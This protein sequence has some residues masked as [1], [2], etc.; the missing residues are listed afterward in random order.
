MARLTG[1]QLLSLKRS[2]L[3]KIFPFLISFIFLTTIFLTKPLSVSAAH[4]DL[5]R[6][7]AWW[8]IKISNPCVPLGTPAMDVSPALFNV[9]CSNG[10]IYKFDP[11]VSVLG[12]APLASGEIAIAYHSS[13]TEGYV[14]SSV[15]NVYRHDSNFIFSSTQPINTAV[16]PGNAPVDLYSTK[17][18]NS[19][20]DVWQFL[21]GNWNKVGS[22]AMGLSEKMVSIDTYIISD[23]GDVYNLP[24]GGNLSSKLNINNF[25]PYAN[26]SSPAVKTVGDYVLAKNGKYYIFNASFGIW[27]DGNVT[28][29]VSFNARSLTLV[30]SDWVLEGGGP[31]S[32]LN[33]KVFNDINGNGIKNAGEDFIQFDTSIV[34]SVTLDGNQIIPNATG[35]YST[36]ITSTPNT[37]SLGINP[38]GSIGSGWGARGCSFSDVAS[39]TYNPPSDPNC[40]GGYCTTSTFSVASGGTITVYLGVSR[41]DLTISAGPSLNSGLLTTGSTVNFK[42]TVKNTGGVTAGGTSNLF[43]I[44]TA[45]GDVTPLQPYP[46]ITALNPGLSQQ[47][48]SG[49]WPFIPSG[50]HTVKLCADQPTSNVIEANESN[51][52]SSWTFTVTTP[53]PT[54]TRTPTPTPTRTPTP[55]PTP[56][57]TYTI[58]GNVYIDDGAGTQC[59]GA[60]CGAGNGLKDGAE[61]NYTATIPTIKIGAM[62][63]TS[64]SGGAYEF[65]G[66]T[67]GGTNYDV[68][69]TAPPRYMISHGGISP[70]TNPRTVIV[71][72]ANEVA[73]FGIVVAP[74][75]YFYM[76]DSSVPHGYGDI[77]EDGQITNL[78]AGLTVIAG[79]LSEIQKK[80]GDVDNN[81]AVDFVGDGITISKFSAGISST[82]WVCASLNYTISGIVYLDENRNGTKDGTEPYYASA[83][84]TRSPGGGVSSPVNN[85]CTADAS[86]A[87][88]TS[89]DANP[90]YSFTELGAGAGGTR[91]YVTI[92]D[93]PAGYV[94]DSA[95]QSLLLGNPGNPERNGTINFALEP[96]PTYTI[97]GSVFVDTNKDGVK[98][99]A[100]VNYTAGSIT[101]T[102]TG[103]TVSYPASGQFTVSNLPAGTYIISYTSLPSEYS[104]IYP[105]T[106]PPSQFEVIVGPPSCS[107]DIAHGSSCLIDDSIINLNFAIAPAD[108]WIQSTCTD[109]RFDNGFNYYI[110]STGTCGGAGGAYASVTAATCTT[111]GIIFSGENNAVF[112]QGNA[113]QTPYGWVVGGSSYPELFTPSR[114]NVIRTSYKYMSGKIKQAGLPPT[115]I[116]GSCGT[117]GKNPCVLGAGFNN[118]LYIADGDLIFSGQGTPKSYTFPE[119]NYVIL[120]DGKLTIK[121]R[122]IVQKGS[123]VT[124]IV[125]GDIIIDPSVGNTNIEGFTSTTP[126]IEGFYSAD[127]SFII[128]GTNNCSV[129]A[130]KRLNIAGSVVVNAGLTGGTF[131]NQ[132]DL[133]AGNATCPAFSIQE[134]PDFILNAPDIIKYQ[135]TI[136]QEVAP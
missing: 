16:Y 77:Y 37:H 94:L 116:T 84:L 136:Y 21:F 9:L 121:A 124:F 122:I 29:P 120:V 123:T 50:T 4:G 5:W 46:T 75:C 105:T 106:G 111:P 13:G 23:K 109:I 127:G 7:G 3:T 102:S 32:T 53:T 93:L 113:S 12:T 73:D 40:A 11:F 20:G 98:N 49:F 52:C 22:Q 112:G 25:P 131:Q 2:F 103:G 96:V 35:D 58:S 48:I 71:Q 107:T 38:S 67:G 14:L 89:C 90:S 76:P 62:N 87:N 59:P 6:P 60:S 61:V 135:N 51:N 56:V 43:E 108:P 129:G 15:G 82:F 85:E 126:H 10:K 88:V 36:V 41:P 28:P 69:L 24:Q 81:G 125:S 44:Y 132:R 64:N 128:Q 110:P 33:V 27:L 54:P 31:I 115:D 45:S 134:R 83:T 42:G 47:V 133:C 65:S 8:E 26:D 57:P 100:E 99:G 30:G 104:M 68:V 118:G 97:S 18:L 130:D 17:V 92:S 114:G 91:Y 63:P 80:A 70:N 117:D 1:T 79:S 19:N 72:N 34:A 55:T 95:T 119:G 74:P 86:K 78:D 66:L 39:C 101:I